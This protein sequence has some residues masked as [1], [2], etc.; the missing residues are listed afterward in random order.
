[1]EL[2]MECEA[3]DDK[4][5]NFIQIALL[6]VNF[7]NNPQVSTRNT[8]SL[9]FGVKFSTQQPQLINANLAECHDR[10]FSIT[11]PTTSVDYSFDCN[12]HVDMV[13]FY[14]SMYTGCVEISVL[15]SD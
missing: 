12:H 1:M 7:E 3:S 10:Y 8:P 11:E 6:G 4:R 5:M 9:N 2:T 14:T 15:N 13:D